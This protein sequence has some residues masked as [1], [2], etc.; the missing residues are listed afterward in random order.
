MGQT[1]LDKPEQYGAPRF[2]WRGNVLL[3][4]ALLLCS[5]SSGCVAISNPV[6][7]GVPVRRLPPDL[8]TESK[9]GKEEIPLTA[10]RQD[11][12]EVYRLAPGDVLGIWIEGVTGTRD[13]LP[14][15]HFPELD[16]PSIGLPVPVRDDGAISLPLVDP[17]RV[18][19]LSLTETQEAIRE[20]YTVKQKI[21]AADKARI[22]VSLMRRRHYRI[23]VLR[24]Q[25]GSP[26]G[27]SGY[28]GSASRGIQFN[29]S[30]GQGAGSSGR[31]SGYAIDLPAYEND[32]LNALARTGGLPGFESLNEVLIERETFKD[33]A[34]RTLIKEQFEKSK[35]RC[36]R[37]TVTRIPMRLR[38]NEPPPFTQ[39][40][41]ILNTGDVVY[42]QA[43]EA[44]LFYTGGLLPPGEYQLPRDY[45]LDILE[46]VLR[47]GG[48]IVSGLNANNVQGSVTGSGL[49]SPSPSL[50][51]VIRKTEHGG[52]AV[53]R[54]DLNRALRDPRE[55]LNVQAGDILVLQEKPSEAMVRYFTQGFFDFSLLSRVISGN[56]TTG[57]IFVNTP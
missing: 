9:E 27:S 31:T 8:F 47:I 54:V 52:Q 11:P 21:L 25:A 29:F 6:A 10:L 48:P 51:S 45:D 1:H 37:G 13:T 55:R 3:L 14:P 7:N 33:D 43:R 24:D 30:G 39:K 20:A 34:D 17:V 22:I 18:T 4:A 40:D 23:L 16:P 44:D 49:G 5:F 35:G 46:V 53:I 26:G 19:G 15:V 36:F 32:V 50:L 12:P 57:T 42:V 38:P 41:I 2:L 28:G 56:K